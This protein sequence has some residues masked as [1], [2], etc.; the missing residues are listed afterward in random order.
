MRKLLTLI[1]I[2]IKC[3]TDFKY[4]QGG[5]IYDRQNSKGVFWQR[6]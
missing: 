3:K 1:N 4:Y 2:N 5:K 6:Q